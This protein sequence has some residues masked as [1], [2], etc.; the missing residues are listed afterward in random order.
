V[1]LFIFGF[2]ICHLFV[3]PLM[4]FPVIKRVLKHKS[5]DWYIAHEKKEAHASVVEK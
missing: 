4:Q 5:K 3:V 1:C 2:G